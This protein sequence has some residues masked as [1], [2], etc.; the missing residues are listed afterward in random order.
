[1]LVSVIIPVFNAEPYIERCIQ[2][3]SSQTYRDFESIFVVDGKCTDNTLQILQNITDTPFSIKIVKQHDDKKAGGARNIGVNNATGDYLWF[4]DVDDCPCNTFMEE[5]VKTITET[6]DDVAICNFCYSRTTDK[7]TIP[8]KNYKN[9]KYTGLE[10]ITA[11]NNGKLSAN[12]WDKL[13]KTS[14]IKDNNISFIAGCS[15]DYA[16]V[17]NS[18]L[19]TD[20]IVYYNK[21]LYVYYLHDDSTS[22]GQGDEIAKRDIEIF[23]EFATKMKESDSP[24]YEE[25]CSTTLRH[26][27][28]SLTN[29]SKSAF[30]RLSKAEIINESLKYKQKGFSMEVF[31]FKISK[32]MFYFIGRNARRLKYSQDRLFFDNDF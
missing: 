1:M 32:R 31:I 26:I 2:V 20:K 5:M 7:Y 28:H 24:Y 21:P 15:E 11:L 19:S 4:M 25:Y 8:E 27:L 30:K 12:I 6:D 13:Y 16:F 9:K 22:K 18:F 10:A 29:V 23:I 17:L 14:F 3:L